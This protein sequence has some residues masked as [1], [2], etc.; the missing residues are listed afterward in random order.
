MVP[1]VPVGH[2]VAGVHVAL[3]G[4]HVL[5]FRLGEPLRVTSVVRRAGVD[6]QVAI[7]STV[8]LRGA[9]LAGLAA[10]A[11]VLGLGVVAEV[12][13]AGA[14]VL[15]A[16]ALGLAVGGGAWLRRL[17]LAGRAR[18]RMPG[19]GS[20]PAIVGAWALEAGVVWAA[21]RGAGVDLTI[22]EAVLV[23]TVTV[24]AQVAAIAPGGFGTYEAAGTAVLVALGVPA[25]TAL[26]VAL[27]AHAIKTS[28]ALVAGAVAVVVPAPVAAGP[29]APATS[30]RR[31]PACAR[32]RRAGRAVPARPRRGGLGRRRRA[33]ACPARSLGRRV[34]CLVVD[35]GST[36]DTAA[37]AA[38]GG[39]RGRP[40]ATQPRARRS[41]PARVRRGRR[42]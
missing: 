27:T 40:P 38:P 25:P 31:P 34:H 42:P 16:V 26:V 23:T 18:L 4:N 32:A 39:R 36:D 29:L 3:L 17:H 6:P 12:S 20:S 21:A 37:V 13:G 11:G 2:G 5:P 10:L 35:D 1:D 14:L 24:A 9:D 8:A 22:P 33:R 19:P 41:R 30:P 15:V 7:A 28:Y